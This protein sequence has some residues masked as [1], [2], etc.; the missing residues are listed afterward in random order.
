MVFS[1]SKLFKS[2]NN[3]ISFKND[4]YI[5]SALDQIDFVIENEEVNDSYISSL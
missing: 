1:T 3:K 2:I 4:N 5:R